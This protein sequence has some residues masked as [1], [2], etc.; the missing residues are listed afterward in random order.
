MTLLQLVRL[1]FKIDVTDTCWNW[2]AA[3]SSDGYGSAWAGG[4][5][6]GA[7]RLM[8]IIFRGGISAGLELDH[9]CKNRACVNPDHLEPVT[10]KVNVLR[11]GSNAAM[12]A[13][14]SLCTAGHT[15][16]PSRNGRTCYRC[17]SKKKRAYYLANRESKIAYA[18]QRRAT[19]TT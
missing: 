4:K 11:G 1:F 14:R 2:T 17:Q 7:H 15:M 8:W 18:R 16:E 12:Y 9:T 5:C 13:R 6:F 10:H 3:K 19:M